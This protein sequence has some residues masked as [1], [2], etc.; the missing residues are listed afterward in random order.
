MFTVLFTVEMYLAKFYKYC[1]V[2]FS[3]SNNNYFTSLR[4]LSE[5]FSS[6]IVGVFSI[7]IQMTVLDV[8]ETVSRCC[9]VTSCDQSHDQVCG[10]DRHSTV[11]QVVKN[12]VNCIHLTKLL[13]RN[14]FSGF[15]E[16]DWNKK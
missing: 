4:V 6:I 7:I 13:M 8:L 1:Y 10:T 11:N 5:L 15:V 9:Q 3:Q 12:I 16:S 14:I 2:V